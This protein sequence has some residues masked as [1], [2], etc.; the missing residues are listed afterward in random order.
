MNRISQNRNKYKI[1]IPRA[2]GFYDTS[3]YAQSVVAAVKYIQNNTKKDEKIFVGN[4]RHDRLVHNDM[5]FYF[6]AERLSA[7]KY[8]QFEPGFTTTRRIQQEIIKDLIRNNV[9]YIVLWN[10][11]ENLY[12]PNESSIS[13]GI[14]DL[15]NFIQE[16]YSIEENFGYHLI[17]KRKSRL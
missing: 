3:E 15:D 13:S 4:L 12:E 6:L 14:K 11:S 2:N 8:Y 17:A 7:T 16:N 5:I 10:A 1:D 9:Q